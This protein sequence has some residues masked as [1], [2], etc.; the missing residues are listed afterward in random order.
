MQFKAFEPGIEVSG[1]C[2]G[3]M[4]DGFRKYPTIALKYLSKHGLVK[5]SGPR[6]GEV[7]RTAWFPLES[8]LSAYE[9]ISSEIGLNSLYACGR[10]IPDNAVFPPNVKDVISAVS[11]IE[12]AYH[13][14]H[15]KGGKIMFDPATGMFLEG[16]GHYRVEAMPA[17]K[18]LIC[19][20]ENPYPCDFDRG[21]VAA[22]ANRF[23]P[24]AKTVHDADQPCRKKGADSCTYVVWW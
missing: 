21:I 13:M 12:V 23:E 1:E 17:E 11:S 8:W 22:M 16:I 9:G 10:S 6:A 20:C 2:V 14:N 18:R 7:D 5:T 24:D 4:V 19:V 15:R 3:S